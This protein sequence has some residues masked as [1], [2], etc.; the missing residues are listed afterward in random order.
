MRHATSLRSRLAD[1]HACADAIAWVG[2]RDLAAAWAECPR[3]D[4]MLWLASRMGVD[5]RLLV[6]AACDCA[7]VVLPRG[8][9]R[10]RHAIETAEAWARGEATIEQV[11]DAA[12]ASADASAEAAEAAVAVAYVG[13]AYVANVAASTARVA[14]RLSTSCTAM[15]RLV[16]A[17]IPID[18]LDGREEASR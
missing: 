5:R 7:R 1:L 11:I 3:G 10:P 18:V 8:D 13:D 16:R 12:D 14:S 15:A 2:D 6:L 9:A 4:W 17:R